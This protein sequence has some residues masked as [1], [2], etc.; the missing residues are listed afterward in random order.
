MEGGLAASAGEWAD[1]ALRVPHGLASCGANET[2]SAR[3][4]C[5]GLHLSNR[6]L[7]ALDGLTRIGA[8][9]PTAWVV[10]VMARSSGIGP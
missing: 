6:G 2:E 3:C 8:R 1:C 10:Y 4:E 7:D 9:L 5:A